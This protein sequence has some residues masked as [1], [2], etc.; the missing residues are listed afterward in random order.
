MWVLNLESLIPR[1][2][3]D[4]SEGLISIDLPVCITGIVLK[5]ELVVAQLAAIVSLA[6]YSR[7]DG[8]VRASL[9]DDVLSAVQQVEVLTIIM[10]C[11]SS[12]VQYSTRAVALPVPV[13]LHTASGNGIAAALSG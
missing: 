12:T 1:L 2:T 10:I 5:R 4:N 7:C 9:K 8:L 11:A 13:A 3:E 6:I